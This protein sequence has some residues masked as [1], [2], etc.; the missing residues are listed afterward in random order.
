[1]SSKEGKIRVRV[2]GEDVKTSL[3]RWS[4]EGERGG[5]TTKKCGVTCEVRGLN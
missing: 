5:E 3:G 2:T 1:M 4:R